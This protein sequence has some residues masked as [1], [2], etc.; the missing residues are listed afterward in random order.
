MCVSGEL[1]LLNG[2]L[3]LLLRNLPA[4]IASREGLIQSHP[5][6]K[7]ATSN[8]KDYFWLLSRLIDK[9]EV[10]QETK[11]QVDIEAAALMVAD[12]ISNHAVRFC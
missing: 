1:D 5:S 10:T 11:E 6:A 4:L 12:F 2:V 8:Y 7:L 9:H 3:N